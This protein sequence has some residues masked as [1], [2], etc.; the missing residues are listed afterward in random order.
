MFHYVFHPHPLLI[1]GCLVA[2]RHLDSCTWWSDSMLLRYIVSPVTVQ[3]YASDYKALSLQ[4]PINYL[5]SPF[6]FIFVPLVVWNCFSHHHLCSIHRYTTSIRSSLARINFIIAISI[7]LSTRISIGLPLSCWDKSYPYPSL[8][9]NLYW[10]LGRVYHSH[11]LLLTAQ[12]GHQ[13]IGWH[14]PHLTIYIRM[15]WLSS[16]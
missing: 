13:P 15:H 6:L 14:H 11:P 16:S 10:T 9:L 4:H 8:F 5:R 7:C 1:G 2:G 3:G 12:L